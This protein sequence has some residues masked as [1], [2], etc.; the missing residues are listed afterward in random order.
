MNR[1]VSVILPTYNG[2]RYIAESIASALAQTLPPHEI[3]VVDDGSTDGTGK[4]V[5]TFGDKVRYIYQNNKGASG[6]YNTGIEA[7]TGDYI[8]FLEH[9]DLWASEKNAS[10]VGF[11]E[12]NESFGMVFCPVELLKE[13]VPSK[14]NDIDSQQGEG[15]YSFADFFGRNRVLNCSSVMLRKSVFQNVSGFREE[16]RLAFDYDLWL[17]IVAKYRVMCLGGASVMYRIHDNNLSKDSH[18]LMA[19]EGSLK[20]MLF[21]AQDAF[22]REQVGTNKI[23]ERVVALYRRVAWDYAQLGQ[24]D[25]ECRYLWAAVKTQPLMLDNWRVYIWRRLDPR[26][27]SRLAWYSQRIRKAFGQAR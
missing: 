12:E 18:E 10:Q 9:D 2:E 25:Q 1:A 14:E 16:L 6:A 13:G 27:R 5:A 11:L 19:A 8:A 23:K 17:R 20:T 21:W 7:A 26:A 24:R 15:E 4:V 3:I 22:A